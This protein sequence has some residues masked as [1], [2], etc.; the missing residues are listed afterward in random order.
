MHRVAPLL[1]QMSD[2]ER[3]NETSPAVKSNS[4]CLTLPFRFSSAID[5]CPPR[6]PRTIAHMATYA[7]S[8]R[9][10]PA[11]VPRKNAP[12][13]DGHE[14]Y[15]NDGG[16]DLRRFTPWLTFERTWLC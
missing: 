7:R 5:V 2:R 1:G 3:L 15:R 14:P 6:A 10:D 16:K 11:A 13:G 9:F 4:A 8:F 12:H